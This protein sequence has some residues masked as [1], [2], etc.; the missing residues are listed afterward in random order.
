M[1]QI[2]YPSTYQFRTIVANVN[3]TYNFI[4]LDEMT[5]EA[6][7]DLT[8]KKPT[9]RFTGT[10]KLH[11][12]NAGC[13]Y[14]EISGIWVQNRENI[15][16]PQKD[17]AGFAFFVESK[18]EVFKKLMNDIK[19]KFN[20]DTTINTISLYG[21]WCGS[22]I[23]KG[24]GISELP[25]KSFFIFAIKI[26]NLNDVSIPSYWVDSKEFRDIEN[27][28]Y[29]IYDFKT[30]SID[31]DFNNPQLIQNK[32]IELTLEV[33]EQ[34][35]VAK[36]LGFDGI[37]EGIVFSYLN[38][39][40][41]TRLVFKSKGEK[42]SKSKVKTLKKVDDEKINR[43]IEVAEKVTPSWR[44]EQMLNE[45]FDLSNGGTISR[46]KMGDYLKKV[47]QDVIKED[48]DILIENNLEIKDLGKYIS[49]ISKNYFFEQEKNNLNLI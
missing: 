4:G 45:T 22:S 38:E 13:C 29:N 28:I 46:N 20:I 42:H 39:S 11:G 12:T 10:C 31:V 16:T 34:C 3:R 25:E 33:E 5:G 49:E 18:K 15:I 17:N 14:N 48:M 37:G 6:I 8:K 41:G 32:I 36:E 7:Y 2:N 40:N 26:S 27:R 23:Q 19:E 24:V 21:E 43:I 47:I 35:P 44:L 30:Y 9:I 1:K